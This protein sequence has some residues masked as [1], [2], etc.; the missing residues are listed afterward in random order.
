V[1]GH[2]KRRRGHEDQLQGPE[3]DVGHGEE[4][5]VAHVLAAG[6]QGVADEVFLFVSPHFLRGH[7]EDHDTE[8]ENDRDP[9]LPDVGGVLVYTPDESVQGPPVHRVILTELNSDDKHGLPKVHRNGLKSYL[10]WCKQF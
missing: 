3:P 9:D 4:V 1:H 10:F 8:N 2:Q 6:L 7:H 5:V